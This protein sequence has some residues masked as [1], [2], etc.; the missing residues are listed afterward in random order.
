VR[1]RLADRR[2]QAVEALSPEHA[3]DDDGKRPRLGEIG[4]ELAD[5]AG[6]PDQQ[7]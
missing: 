3:V 6:E 1:E 4:D 5:T 2:E 7:P